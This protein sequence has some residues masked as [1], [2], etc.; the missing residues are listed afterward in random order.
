MGLKARPP[1][2]VHDQWML[3]SFA[4]V[5]GFLGGA[6]VYASDVSDAADKAWDMGI[7]PGG[8]VLAFPIPEAFTIPDRFQKKLLTRDE[9]NELDAFWQEEKREQMN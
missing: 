4:N 8:E 3:L 1:K 7:N 5:E 6:V 9:C 2:T